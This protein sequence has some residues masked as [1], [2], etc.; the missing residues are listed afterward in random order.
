LPQT[1][2]RF[3]DF[4][5]LRQ[6]G[7]GSFGKVF[8]AR[9]V[10]L[11][12]LV[13][14][15]VSANVGHEARTLA[16]LEHAHIVQVFS[17]QID[18]QRSLRLLCMQYVPG[19]T[20]ERV[21]GLLKMREPHRRDGRAILEI[22][23]AADSG[24][25]ALDP[26][27]LREREFL[28][29]CDNVE[30]VCWL[31]ARLAEALAHA[32]GL[33]VLHRDVKPANIL[34]SRYGRP[35]LA[36]FN[37]ASDPAKPEGEAG[38]LGGTLA[39]MAPEHLDA[40]L[41]PIPFNPTVDERADLYS[42]GMVLFELV[43][44]QLPLAEEEPSRK[45]RELIQFLADQRHAGPPALPPE[46]E[47]PTALAC[48]L[49]RCQEPEPEK[50]FAF[51]TELA[52]ALD[53]CRELRRIEK[54][55]PP[56]G[57]LTRALEHW[58]FALGFLL[59]L[60]PH[61]LGSIV[62]ISYNALQIVGRLTEEQQATFL[63]LVPSY[64]ALTYPIAVIAVLAF[65]RPVQRLLRQLS[66]NESV[67]GEEVAAMRR[68]VLKLPAW[69]VFLSCLGWLPG[70][71]LFPFFLDHWAGPIS[72][73]VY[74]QFLISFTISGLIALTY[75]FFAIQ[76]LVLRVLYPTLWTDARQIHAVAREELRGTRDRLG[77]FQFLAVLIPLAAAVLM[78][79]IGGE[80]FDSA[81]YRTFR[82]LVTVLITLGMTG[83][84]VAMLVSRRLT[85]TLS[86]LIESSSPGAT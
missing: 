34:L 29:R 64:N 46:A 5:L 48:V 15:K 12:R 9:Q 77:L 37:V 30:A 17:E 66:A 27:A 36:D 68:R 72:G 78:V 74:V 84:G 52:A 71:L 4:E 65:I 7:Q 79:G 42:L 47:V 54:A 51:A 76:Y 25:V 61:F 45:L 3:D 28:A 6:L 8:L 35:Y 73:A 13:A 57:R 41:T 67:S 14:L 69:C 55:L 40:F 53:G 23:D 38:S 56:A 43:T 21:I 26:T 49:R 59:A 39:Y 70:G 60:L 32:H 22:L 33:G 20:L 81:D 58:P 1:G 63:W 11:D 2:E 83:L 16:R 86:A 24:P 85:E 82:L 18:S 10:S 80:G 19:A 31:G 62:N 50:R 75:S 44:G